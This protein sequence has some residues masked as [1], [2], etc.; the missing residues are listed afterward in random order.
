MKFT[1]FSFFLF[2]TTTVFSQN[3][4]VSEGLDVRTDRTYELLGDFEDKYMIA[5]YSEDAFT[6]HNFNQDLF[7]TSAQEFNLPHKKCR[8]IHMY[9]YEDR[10]FVLYSAEEKDTLYIV[11]QSYQP[12]FEKIKTDTIL[13]LERNFQNYS[14]RYTFSEDRS[15]FGLTVIRSNEIIGYAVYD[16]KYEEI[17]QTSAIQLAD[18][19]F[20]DDYRKSLVTNSGIFYLIFEQN[21]FL[22]KK[23]DHAFFIY[24]LREAGEME[25]SILPMKS[26]LVYDANFLYDNQNH[27]LII[28]GLGSEKDLNRAELIFR[29]KQDPKDQDVFEYATFVFHNN[30]L[31]DFYGND[32]RAKFDYLEDIQIQDVILMDNGSTIMVLEEVQK[33]ERMTSSGRIDYYGS[34]YTVDYHYENLLLFHLSSNENDSW[35]KLLPKRQ[36]S[37]DDEG[38]Y[39][40]YF[41]FKNPNHLRLIYNDEIRNENT[42]SE[43][44]IRPNGASLRTNLLSTDFQKLR[45]QVRNGMQLSGHRVLI[46]S[47]RGKVLKLLMIDYLN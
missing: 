5:S 9:S 27:K 17:V 33:M 39:S 12:N 37:N 41:L 42:V 36:F 2:L 22:Y 30:L 47:M 4:V 35:Q 29:V 1:I 10:Y 11:N 44:I 45:L 23:E 38:A 3:I 16:I 6:L 7:L 24:K 13:K 43:Y 18:F 21:N 26:L 19:D 28:C 46:P 34:R 15:K 31:N 40:S 32:R 20:Y 14:F 25:E 8:I